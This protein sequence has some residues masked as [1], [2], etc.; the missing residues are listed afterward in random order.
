M[1][2][3]GLGTSN[4][5]LMTI[6]SQ[7]QRSVCEIDAS[8]ACQGGGHVRQRPEQGESCMFN[9][10]HCTLLKNASYVGQPTDHRA[11]SRAV[12]DREE[13][14]DSVFLSCIHFVGKTYQ[15]VVIFF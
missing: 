10:Q 2:R 11:G 1:D 7:R 13:L 6:S 8:L 5:S 9:V 14:S 15:P 4:L 3:L 12:R